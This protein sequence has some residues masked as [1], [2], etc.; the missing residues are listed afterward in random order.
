MR[1]GQIRKIQKQLTLSIKYSRFLLEIAALHQSLTG[2]KKL[3]STRRSELKKK[4]AFAEYYKDNIEATHRK[5]DYLLLENG[6]V[7]NLVSK[8]RPEKSALFVFYSIAITTI[9][10]ESFAFSPQLA[11]FTN[12]SLELFNNRHA[13]N[14]IN[15]TYTRL[16]DVMYGDEVKVNGLPATR[17]GGK[18][19]PL[20]N[21]F[22]VFS[23]SK[24][25]EKVLPPKQETNTYVH[26]N[27]L[28][29]TKVAKHNSALTPFEYSKVL[30]QRA[31][32]LHYAS[33]SLGRVN[34]KEYSRTLMIEVNTE[35]QMVA[36]KLL[37]EWYDTPENSAKL[38]ILTNFDNYIIQVIKSQL[39]S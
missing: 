34:F 9:I 31:L 8:L 7:S 15:E 13:F 16:R 29:A 5:K 36:R 32:Y 33:L 39:S 18:N 10:D 11:F 22:K 3:S 17:S 35:R 14:D 4:L 23:F 27:R 37:E 38:R 6:D 26:H 20:K 25:S 30:A 2:T 28:S 21:I 19:V 24:K 12:L 1:K